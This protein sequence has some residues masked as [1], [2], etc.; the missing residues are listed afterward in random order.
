MECNAKSSPLLHLPGEIRNSIYEY[1]L[2]EDAPYRLATAMIL[3]DLRKVSL[4]PVVP[5]R[6]ALLRT[7][8]QLYLETA[9]LPFQLN[10][11][12]F[13]SRT[14]RDFVSSQLTRAQRHAI[15]G[16]ETC[17]HAGEGLWWL[18]S[19]VESLWSPRYEKVA[20]AADDLAFRTLLP[21][22][23]NIKI[24]VSEIRFRAWSV[25]E[26]DT[27]IHARENLRVW[28]RNGNLERVKVVIEEVWPA[29]AID[30]NG[31]I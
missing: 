9:L 3:E 22:L 1:V 10:I 13:R 31:L 2:Q 28:L 26:D 24:K 19:R 12:A 17:I 27:T 20:I 30:K 11:F 21:G 16:I 7:C 6:L 18:V 8:R 29:I 23:Q 25:P 15:R 5:H 4:F 14:F